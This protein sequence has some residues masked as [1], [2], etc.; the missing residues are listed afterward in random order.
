MSS[1]RTL[2]AQ[3]EE[4]NIMLDKNS[5][6][7][8]HAKMLQSVA[9]Q[10]FPNFTEKQLPGALPSVVLPPTPPKD[11]DTVHL[12]MPVRIWRQIQYFLSL[13]LPY[14][15]YAWLMPQT[16]DDGAEQR[17]RPARDAQIVDAESP[18]ADDLATSETYRG[19]CDGGSPEGRAFHAE[20]QHPQKCVKY[21]PP[22]C[23]RGLGVPELSAEDTGRYF[24]VPYSGLGGYMSLGLAS[25]IMPRDDGTIMV[26]HE[27]CMLLH[28]FIEGLR[29]TT[30]LMAA[31]AY[32]SVTQMVVGMGDLAKRQWI[33]LLT[34]AL[35][36]AG[37]RE[38]LQE[39]I[40]KLL[41]LSQIYKTPT[42]AKN[43]AEVAEARARVD[44][45]TARSMAARKIIAD[46]TG[47]T[48]KSAAASAAEVACVEREQAEADAKLKLRL[49]KMSDGFFV[50]L[51]KR[52][53]RSS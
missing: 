48:Q 49:E 36:K 29:G 22:P 53:F 2:G 16:C 37:G 12:H 44:E 35:C 18:S 52:L 42:E 34:V 38:N 43:D 50:M 9:R 13:I 30:P 10:D 6:A 41:E 14:T 33:I 46:A 47:E 8:E 15:F 28:E 39:E 31:K 11:T 26:T 25:C 32:V 20:L 23:V 21:V 40:G 17:L 5:P 4:A 3:Y 24:V 27:G 7:M 45:A 1:R 51:G 19:G